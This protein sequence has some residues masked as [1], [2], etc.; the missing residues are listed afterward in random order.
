MGLLLRD[1]THNNEE[2][3]VIFK[4]CTT[5]HQVSKTVLRNP[6]FLSEMLPSNIS[7]TAS[8]PTDYVSRTTQ[9]ATL[10]SGV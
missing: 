2:E 1:S 8:S 5:V 7:D 4:T 10:L 3:K 6:Q 9:R